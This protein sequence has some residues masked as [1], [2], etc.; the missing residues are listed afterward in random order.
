MLSRVVLIV[1]CI[2]VVIGTGC[3]GMPRERTDYV[4]QP[5]VAGVEWKLYGVPRENASFMMPKY[6]VRDRVSEPADDAVGYRY[7]AYADEAVYEFR[8]YVKDDTC[9]L[10]CFLNLFTETR[11]PARYAELNSFKPAPVEIEDV[12]MAERTVR[13][14]RWETENEVALR[15]VFPDLGNDRW[16]ELAVSYRPDK[17]PD[18][19]RF[20]NSLSFSNRIDAEQIGAGAAEI[21]G[22]SDPPSEPSAAVDPISA[23]MISKTQPR[24]EYTDPAAEMETEGE[25]LVSAQFLADGTVGDVQ[26]IKGLTNGLNDEA[27]KAARRMAFLPA[28]NN[29][30]PADIIRQISYTFSIY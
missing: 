30:T 1:I 5:R 24:P 27:I 10:L 13:A 11:L 22:D 15:W 14:Y 6:P 18:I 7:T 9:S 26:V 25:V 12:H 16:L 8:S 17:W 29:G 19:H 2:A 28:R 21:V 3:A 4:L 23:P 20:L